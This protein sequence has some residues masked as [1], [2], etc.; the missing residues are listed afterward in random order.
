V[1]A[2]ARSQSP[3]ANSVRVTVEN[4]A[5]AETDN[6]LALNAKEAGVGKINSRGNRTARWCYGQ[7]RRA[8]NPA[9]PN[10]QAM[11]V[12]SLYDSTCAN[13]TAAELRSYHAW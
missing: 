1:P 12:A 6:Y 3:S 7:S 13:V 10:L 8:G 5:R 4:F 9:K 11:A 2:N